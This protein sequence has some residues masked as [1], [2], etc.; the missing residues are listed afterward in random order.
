MHLSKKF[1]GISQGKKK[2]KEEKNFFEI[3]L[4]L[5]HRGYQL[6]WYCNVAVR[7]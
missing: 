2:K 5:L 6:L 7:I 1:F 4:I 3:Y